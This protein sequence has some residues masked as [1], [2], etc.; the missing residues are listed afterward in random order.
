MQTAYFARRWRTN[1]HPILP[2]V[3]Q[4][5]ADGD[6]ILD[7]RFKSAFCVSASAIADV[8]GADVRIAL[9]PIP[10]IASASTL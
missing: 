4:Q 2:K 1:K 9:H 5:V 8:Q 10:R 3:L 7:V 6:S